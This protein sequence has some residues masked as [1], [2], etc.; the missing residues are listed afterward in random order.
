MAS[1]SQA[2]SNAGKVSKMTKFRIGSI[3]SLIR[4]YRFGAGQAVYP[5]RRQNGDF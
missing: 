2:T 3:L 4:G 1:L 5:D